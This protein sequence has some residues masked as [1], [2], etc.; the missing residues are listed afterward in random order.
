MAQNWTDDSYDPDHV[1]Q[2]DLQNMENNFG[3]LKS[4]FSGGSQPSSPVAGQPWVDTT[5]SLLKVRNLANSA[6]VTIWDFTTDTVPT[7]AVDEDAIQDDAVTTDKLFALAVTAAKLAVDSVI[8]AK[9]Q[10]GAITAAKLASDVKTITGV[11]I[12][13][14]YSSQVIAANFA[15]LVIL[16]EEIDSENICSLANSQ[17]TLD[18]GTYIIDFDSSYSGASQDV[19]FRLYNASIAADIKIWHERA[20]THISLSNYFTLASP[21]TLE[22]HGRTN[23]SAVLQGH[24]IKLIRVGG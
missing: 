17:F 20:G 23:D 22:L 6:W 16:D 10:D 18:T 14:T 5:N 2:T 15:K 21:Q 11:V 4:S 1:G 9:I 12:L 13:S 24:Q 7:D 19:D 8:T 3:C